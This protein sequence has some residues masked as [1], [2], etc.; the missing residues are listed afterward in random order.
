ME[1]TSQLYRA[2]SDSK[3]V[4][5]WGGIVAL[6]L[7]LSCPVDRALAENVLSLY[8]G[9][10]VTDSATVT[11]TDILATP[12]V[13]ITREVDFDVGV[14]VGFRYT[15]WWRVFGLSFDISYFTVEP[16]STE[17]VSYDVIPLSLLFMARWPLLQG[18]RF[19]KG[20]FHPYI[21]IGPTW[22]P[23]EFQ[24]SDVSLPYGGGDGSGDDTTVTGLLGFNW[25]LTR[26]HSLFMEF[27]YTDIDVAT[28]DSNSYWG[29]PA[30][31][32]LDGELA[33]NHF[34]IGYSFAF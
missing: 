18:P 13:R 19:P 31:L 11:V 22:A 17:L 20:R 24:V 12:P 7:V 30:K 10:T 8:G 4:R 34:V 25:Q 16:H 5:R 14:E 3:T 32:Q 26:R 1:A 33:T 28:D 6:L 9:A 29:I 2:P 23:Y 15:W 21:G 27:K